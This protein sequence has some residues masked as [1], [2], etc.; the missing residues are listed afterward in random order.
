MILGKTDR[1][2]VVRAEEAKE[3]LVGFLG[4]YRVDNLDALRREEAK[5]RPR[6]HVAYHLTELGH[7]LAE[8]QNRIMDG[9]WE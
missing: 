5:A 9:E 1:A 6:R 7:V 8:I 3:A 2:R 4:R